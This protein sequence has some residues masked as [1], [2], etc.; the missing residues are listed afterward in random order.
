MDLVSY[1][2]KRVHIVLKDGFFYIG[3]VFFAD[4]SSLSLI[5]KTGALV[6][7]SADSIQVIKEV[8]R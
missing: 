5:D 6:S 1:K 2:N 3:T 4:G 8:G 7:V